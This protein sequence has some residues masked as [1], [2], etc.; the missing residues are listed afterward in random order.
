MVEVRRYAR[1]E[2]V[3]VRIEILV[4][5]PERQTLEVSQPAMIRSAPRVLAQEKF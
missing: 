5:I 2:Q 4:D 3:I 1:E